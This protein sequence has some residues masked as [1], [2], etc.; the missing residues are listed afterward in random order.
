MAGT[1]YVGRTPDS[2]SVEIPKSFADAQIAAGLPSVTSVRNAITAKVNSLA[3]VT[4]GYVNQSNA[5]RAQKTAVDAAD[6]AYVPV[7]QLNQPNGVAGLDGSGNLFGAQIPPGVP[8]EYTAVCYNASID[9]VVF[10][11]DIETVNTDTL[12]ELLIARITVADPGYPWRPIPRGVVQGGNPNGTAPSN[13]LQGTA[14]YGLLSVIPPEGV[15]DQVYGAGICTDSFYFDFYEVMPYASASQT[16][17]SVPAIVGGLELDLYGCCWSG[18]G[19]QFG[20]AGLFYS[21]LVAPA[22]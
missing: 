16:P 14:N 10:L 12:R 2:D 13:R 8:T 3:L 11:E 5:Q 1:W 21:I 19:Y 15:S 18:S 9:G 7:G 17:T 20:P 22:M 6:L 4:P